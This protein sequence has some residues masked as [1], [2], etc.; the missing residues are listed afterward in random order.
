MKEL[1]P[2]ERGCRAVTERIVEA[3]AVV[4]ENEIPKTAMVKLVCNSK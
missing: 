1:Q 4:E 3:V 2:A